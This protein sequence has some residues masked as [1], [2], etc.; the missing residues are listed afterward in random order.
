ML[1]DA[2]GAILSNGFIDPEDLSKLVPKSQLHVSDIYKIILAQLP[3]NGVRAIRSLRFFSDSTPSGNEWSI[4]LDP[5]KSPRLHADLC[6][7][8]YSKGQLPVEFDISRAKLKLNERLANYNKIRREPYEL[9]HTIPHGKHYDFSDYTSIQRE[10]PKVYG[11]NENQLPVIPAR[12]SD[13][14]QQA[15]LLRRQQALQ[16]KGYLAFFDQMLANY[17]SQ[18]ANVRKL[19]A[20]RPAEALANSYFNAELTS[21]PDAELIL[22][23]TELRLGK[24][25]SGY[26]LY[27]GRPMA[28]LSVT[29]WHKKL[30]Y[31][32]FQENF[33]TCDLR[34][35]AVHFF[36][37]AFDND[38]VVLEITDRQKTENPNIATCERFFFTYRLPGSNAVLCSTELFETEEAAR[39][40]AELLRY[41]GILHRC[42]K[43][44]DAGSGFGAQV[45]YDPLDY[46]A[47]LDYITESPERFYVRREK[48]L[49]HLLARFSEQFTE[50]T[51]LMYAM[52]GQAKSQDDIIKDKARFLSRYDEIS[53]NRAKAFDYTRSPVWDTDNV[54]GFE[55]RVAGFMG[56]D[57]WKRKTL[58]HLKL[59]QSEVGNLTQWS[60]LDTPLFQTHQH[61]TNADYLKNLFKHKQVVPIDCPE[62]SEYGFFLKDPGTGEHVSCLTTFPSA[63]ER[64]DAVRFWQNWF[65]NAPVDVVQRNDRFCFEIIDAHENVIL[66][67]IKRFNKKSAVK[68]AFY[69]A[70]QWALAPGNYTKTSD[71]DGH[72]F[73]LLDPHNKTVATCPLRFPDEGERDMLLQQFIAFLQ[74]RWIPQRVQKTAAFLDWK[75]VST[76]GETLFVSALRHKRKDFTGVF[77]TMWQALQWARQS[78]SW[79]IAKDGQNHYYL[80][81]INA[82]AVARLFL[83]QEKPQNWIEIGRS[84]VFYDNESEAAA[85]LTQ[86]KTA[87]QE[88]SFLESS[89][90][91]DKDGQYRFQFI[92]PGESEVILKSMDRFATKAQAAICFERFL[93]MATNP[94]NFQHRNDN[95]LIVDIGE[96]SYAISANPVP[97]ATA[98]AFIAYLAG[99]IKEQRK[100]MSALVERKGEFYHVFQVSQRNTNDRH[101]LFGNR[102]YPTRREAY[103]DLPFLLSCFHDKGL[104]AIPAQP[105]EGWRL[106]LSDAGKIIAEAEQEFVKKPNWFLPASTGIYACW[107]A[108]SYRYRIGF[109]D[110]S[111]RLQYLLS[112][113]ELFFDTPQAALS[114]GSAALKN[115]TDTCPPPVSGKAK[116]AKK[117]IQN[118][119]TFLSVKDGILYLLAC[120]DQQVLALC[121][122]E[123]PTQMAQY[124]FKFLTEALTFSSSQTKEIPV[125]ADYPPGE[126]ERLFQQK[127]ANRFRLRDEGYALAR[128]YTT[129]DTPAER[130]T[131]ANAFLKYWKK[132]DRNFPSIHFA[133]SRKDD[134]VVE[135]KECPP[136]KGEASVKP[137]SYYFKLTC[138][139]ECLSFVSFDR[140]ATDAD[141]QEQ[142]SD[143]S[144]VYNMNLLREEDAYV[145]HDLDGTGTQL[146][147]QVFDSQKIGMRPRLIVEQKFEGHDMACGAIKRILHCAK[148]YPFY[149]DDENAIRFRLYNTSMK[150]Y[151][152]LSTAGYAS[153]HEARLAF[154]EFL[155]LLAYPANLERTTKPFSLRVGEILL[156]SALA[157]TPTDNEY[158]GC[159]DHI[160]AET[161]VWSAGVEEQ[162]MARVFE[163]DGVVMADVDG[164]GYTFRVVNPAYRLARHPYL[165]Q[166]ATER[167]Q[168]LKAIQALYTCE[169]APRTMIIQGEITPSR[170]EQIIK[171]GELSVVEHE[172]YATF[173]FGPVAGTGDIA[174][175]WRMALGSKE[176]ITATSA[177][178][179]L[180]PWAEYPEFYLK[181]VQTGEDGRPKADSFSLFL[182]DEDGRQR[183]FAIVNGSH[184]MDAATADLAIRTTVLQAREHPVK[185]QRPTR[186]TEEPVFVY[187]IY[188]R[189]WQPSDVQEPYGI[190]GAYIWESTVP[191]T[192]DAETYFRECYSQW[193]QPAAQT[194]FAFQHTREPACG[195][196]CGGFGFDAVD[197]EQIIAYYPALFGTRCEAEE[198]IQRM[199]RLI[200]VEG[201]HLLENILLRPVRP[202]NEPGAQLP[203][204]SLLLSLSKDLTALWSPA[205]RISK[206]F[207]NTQFN[208]CF[209]EYLPGSDPYSSQVTI[210]LPYWAR[211]FQNARFREFFENTLRRELPAHCRLRAVWVTPADMYQFEKV[212]RAWLTGMAA[213]ESEPYKADLVANLND[214][215]SYYKLILNDPKAFLDTATLS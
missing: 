56:I 119:A 103:K 193:Q 206:G 180:T 42:Y 196:G 139:N 32:D 200:D 165:Y 106:I 197:P 73:D 164:C 98:P 54:S 25:A 157:Y 107:A 82:D 117:A 125:Q 96:G 87:V 147:L 184:I 122:P 11:I 29:A 133:A 24:F 211:R 95:Y 59:T 115:L 65:A 86:L 142:I 116:S 27:K 105:S 177:W 26:H 144:L 91:L 57:D 120:A 138:G 170:S 149:L 156:E 131:A 123:V 183:A 34:D 204:D 62:E 185:Q 23:R 55:Q 68:R 154:M 12:A 159:P 17:L 114:A 63:A 152:W 195:C 77:E 67:G 136:R 6:Q 146:E 19:F 16:L 174:L 163:D 28:T 80:S 186:P 53:R 50:Y 49:D 93:K 85:A 198:G 118:V 41:L 78:G 153:I 47:F 9:G 167:T 40:S 201:F 189:R 143:V 58:N 1:R 168:H 110:C 171:N 215:K 22:G 188:S 83:P 150:E 52:D 108:D 2:K 151:E 155:R 141:A 30:T 43:N 126:I 79:R 173:Q 190:T 33:S 140:F 5:L 145:I 35:S 38:S 102:R 207:F 208:M 214:L 132:A 179:P 169:S 71:A 137:Y 194:V 162:L 36:R 112:E 88:L 44:N 101:T 4:N 69:R 182:L 92:F 175:T 192:G 18:L 84:A 178:Y 109:P 209:E 45:V 121:A 37:E 20:V 100:Q 60:I 75:V 176:E 70:V 203:K 13:M 205:F 64:D 134:L 39:E 21:M 66:K 172:R 213:G 48:F 202:E 51:L 81:L 97:A 212:Y 74:E 7:I 181:Q 160:R 161:K 191:P 90:I 128:Y 3:G 10:F 8:F 94:D 129:F 14:E 61:I 199:L 135:V 113:A 187:K 210:I 130:E 31:H 15:I 166:T 148:T 158:I 76:S 104:T 99:R 46:A 72:Y 89:L 124:A 111:G 127:P